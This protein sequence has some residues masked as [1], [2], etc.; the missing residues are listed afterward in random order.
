MGK[1][2][3]ISTLFANL[4]LKKI[5]LTAL[6]SAVGILLVVSTLAVREWYIHRHCSSLLEKSRLIQVHFTELSEYITEQLL[7]NQIISMMQVEHEAAI[8]G[9]KSSEIAGHPLVPVEFRLLLISR[10]DLTKLMAR[11][12]LLAT[13]SDQTQKHLTIY[14]MLS[15]L[16]GRI[17]VFDDGFSKYIQQQVQN[18]QNLLRGFLAMAT[19]FLATLLFL[20][21]VRITQPFLLMAKELRSALGQDRQDQYTMDSI[22]S[23]ADL[24]HKIRQELAACAFYKYFL[25]A[26]PDLEAKQNERDQQA[27][28]VWQMLTPLLEQ[29]PDYQLVLTSFFSEDRFTREI[30][31]YL[32]DEVRNH[33]VAIFRQ[34]NDLAFSLFRNISPY[35]GEIHAAVCFSIAADSDRPGMVTILSDNPESFT[36][37]EVGVLST[38]LR[39]FEYIDSSMRQ[40]GNGKVEFTLEELRAMSLTLLNEFPPYRECHKIMDSANGIINCAQI[41]QDQCKE[42]SQEEVNQKLLTDL[43][44]SGK[45]IADSVIRLRSLQQMHITPVTSID[46]VLSLLISRL[47]LQYPEVSQ[48]LQEEPLPNLPT[49]QIPGRDLLLALTL[50]AE[51]VIPDPGSDHGSCI[52]TK[53]RIEAYASTLKETIIKLVLEPESVKFPDKSLNTTIHIRQLLCNA[54]L[55]CHGSALEISRMKNQPLIYRF[56]LR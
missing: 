7:A 46:E 51:Q 8:I 49:V 2:S 5:I 34:K 1:N 37:Q 41:L 23:M 29:H 12:R 4:S 28:S 14:H 54:I 50:M 56:L 20:L 25:G 15:E 6:L 3:A 47:T 11:I 35:S 17:V 31:D 45:K 33:G 39:F 30:P 36:D 44:E 16:N 19:V 22:L 18:A 26:P 27:G 21:Y 10:N 32:L 43:W 55:H 13:G 48:I 38:L 52:F 42:E 24:G 40:A 9:E 53:L